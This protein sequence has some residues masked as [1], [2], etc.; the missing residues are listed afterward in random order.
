MM[1]LKPS[2]I[3]FSQ[4][5]VNNFFDK[6]SRHSGILI[7]E[8]L[9]DICEG[10][11][12]VDD[13]PTI[14]VMNR[15]GKWVTS[16]NRRLWVF[17]EL[18]RLGR[19]DDIP[20]IETYYIP[21]EKLN[22][23]NG[24]LSVRVRRYA[25]GHWHNKRSAPR[26]Q[27]RKDTNISIKGNNKNH[28]TAH[29]TPKPAAVDTTENYHPIIANTTSY[30]PISTRPV[31]PSWRSSVEASNERY[32]LGGPTKSNTV[33]RVGQRSVIPDWNELN[34]NRS[35]HT[36]KLMH[37]GFG[38]SGSVNSPSYSYGDTRPSRSAAIYPR[39]GTA[40][41]FSGYRGGHTENLTTSDDDGQSFGKISGSY[42]NRSERKSPSSQDNAVS[43]DMHDN[44]V[45]MYGYDT[46]SRG[47]C[48]CIIL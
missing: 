29:L 31:G 20:V 34:T 35:Q 41:R 30:A 44:D 5:S 12:T 46:I 32:L 27:Q 8:T 25:G 17:R 24:G 19:C 38:T 23:V 4:E 3:L 14:R 9:D 36:S 13:I 2:D 22:S 15:N 40:D 45:D 26:V 11:C 42:S 47:Q 33:D 43:L 39:S 1:R 48:P 21:P 18:E 16:D 7:G 6:R 10:R 28:F 37:S